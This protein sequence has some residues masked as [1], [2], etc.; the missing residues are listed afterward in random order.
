MGRG[1]R[2]K[3]SRLAEE[4]LSIRSSLNLSQAELVERIWDEDNRI[5]KADISKYES[6]LSEPSLVT[7]LRYA[8]LAK[9]P[10]EVLVDDNLDLPKKFST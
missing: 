8:R 9:T 5:Y 2:K 4:L 10:M 6:G 1:R 3:P 7:L